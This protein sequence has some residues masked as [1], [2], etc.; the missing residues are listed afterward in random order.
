MGWGRKGSKWGS[1]LCRAVVP[2]QAL[3]PQ[4]PGAAGAQSDTIPG[5]LHPQTPEHPGRA[6]LKL[7]LMHLVHLCLSLT[8]LSCPH[9]ACRWRIEHTFLCTYLFSV[10]V[11]SLLKSMRGST[12]QAPHKGFDPQHSVIFPTVVKCRQLFWQ[13]KHQSL[14]LNFTTSPPTKQD[15]RPLS[16]V[17]K[18]WSSL[19]SLCLWAEEEH[20]LILNI[21]AAHSFCLGR[22]F[23]PGWGSLCGFGVP[24]P[25]Q[26]CVSRFLPPSSPELHVL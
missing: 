24:H 14:Q 10:Q 7:L 16:Q 25:C 17:R 22:N 23:H 4:S 5:S 12:P 13:N 9:L 1:D 3:P 8:L 11:V 19:A 15:L 20:S 6:L 21:P 2:S 18:N 26:R